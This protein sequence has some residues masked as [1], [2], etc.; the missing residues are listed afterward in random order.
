MA[1]S[2]GSLSAQSA[3]APRPN[4][5]SSRNL[6]SSSDGRLPKRRKNRSMIQ[7]STA[8]AATLARTKAS[9]FSE[10]LHRERGKHQAKRE[11]RGKVVHETGRQHGLAVVGT[12]ETELEHD[13]VD[14]GDRR[15]RECDTGEPARFFDQP[16]TK[17]AMAVQPRNGARKPTMPT[18]H[19]SFHDLRMTSGSSS[20]P[21]RNVRGTAPV[22][23]RNLTHDWSVPSTATPMSAPGSS[24]ATVPTTISDVAE[25]SDTSW[26]PRGR[27]ACRTAF[28]RSSLPASFTM[29]TSKPA[30]LERTNSAFGS[31]LPRRSPGV[32]VPFSLA[33]LA[34]NE[35]S[36]VLGKTDVEENDV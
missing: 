22:D 3:S 18:L 14:H 29:F 23:E 15:R 1:G 24:C 31:S 27:T 17:N 26:R 8:K 19:V 2:T 35:V 6:V 32:A 4:M 10:R 20:A 25:S 7:G 34:A 12:V 11:H 13:G 33:S 9:V 30:S 16:R 21:A 5:Q 28:M 36:L